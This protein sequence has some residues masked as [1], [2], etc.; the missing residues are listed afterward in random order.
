M[1]EDAGVLSWVHRVK[2]V[3]ERCSDLLGD[4]GWRWRV[5]RTSNAY[6]F[7]DPGLPDPS[8]SD[9]QTGTPNQEFFSKKGARRRRKLTARR[10]AKPPLPDSPKAESS[11]SRL[12][13]EKQVPNKAPAPFAE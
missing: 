3:R 7:R 1:L 9:F 10:A 5:L 11:H 4:N 2:R 6:T 8:K 13:G 12:I